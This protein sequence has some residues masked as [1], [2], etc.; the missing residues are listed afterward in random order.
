M[1]KVWSNSDQ[2]KHNHPTLKKQAPKNQENKPR[3]FSQMNLYFLLWL[4][5]CGPALAIT[6]KNLG[7]LWYPQ[8]CK[9]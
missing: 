1:G 3:Q 5:Y 4:F 6:L 7:I 8:L 2:T 9:Q